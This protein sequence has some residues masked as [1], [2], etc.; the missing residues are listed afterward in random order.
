MAEN[1]LKKRSRQRFNVEQWT[2]GTT[3]FSVERTAVGRF[4]M[5]YWLTKWSLLA[6]AIF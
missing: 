3:R 4:F 5:Q 2:I 6:V 1:H